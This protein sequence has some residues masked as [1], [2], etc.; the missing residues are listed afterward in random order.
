MKK[1]RILALMMAFTMVANVFVTPVFAT[2]GIPRNEYA[3]NDLVGE[4]DVHS[5]VLHVLVPTDLNF[6]LDPFMMT[7]VGELRAG[8]QNQ[9]LSQI[10]EADFEIIN[11][12][13]APVAAVF[14]V[15][16]VLANDVTLITRTQA[17]APNAN[18][19]HYF[20]PVS[21]NYREKV[22]HLNVL[23]A[24]A[25]DRGA[26]EFGED[27][28][29]E[30]ARLT[31]ASPATTPTDEPFTSF[32]QNE[33]VGPFIADFAFVLDAAKGAT[34]EGF[35]R[36]GAAPLPDTSA[37]AAHAAG[38]LA[39]FTSTNGW[40]YTPSDG[41]IAHAD[42]GDTAIARQVQ[43]SPGVYEWYVTPADEA[44]SSF[45][46]QVDEND[47]WVWVEATDGDIDN[48]SLASFVFYAGMN[49]F[50]PWQN[51]DVD[52]EA[53]LWLTPLH[54]DQVA[55]TPGPLYT[56]QTLGHNK[57]PE[58]QVPDR[59]LPAEI[60]AEFVGFHRLA[61]SAPGFSIQS[62]TEATLNVA[63]TAGTLF[64]P[65]VGATTANTV[66]RAHTG[67]VI[68]ATNYTVTA[69]GITFTLDRSN[70]LREHAGVAV[71]SYELVVGGESFTLNFTGA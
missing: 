66:V 38:T 6:T 2:G 28:F 13:L 44:P 8:T 35:V 20:N 39:G 16:A 17:L 14:Y 40:T 25:I 5:P 36:G 23:G 70:I 37:T 56:S 31:F 51:G 52:V 69:S 30:D 21:M 10:L 54:R 57:F 62:A 61:G 68:A 47:Y 22:L 53:V 63:G 4:S 19:A 41:H 7:G 65:F 71:P 32:A 9:Q 29:A 18:E 33:G 1:K 12:T 46:V 27:E 15:N 67:A 43:G 3:V 55:D 45:S 26:T 11:N 59:L 50:A 58:E 34:P 42:S 49:T 64:V 48:G 24:N 60:P